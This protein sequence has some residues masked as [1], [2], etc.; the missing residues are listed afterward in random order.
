[1]QPT[2]QTG[3]AE[4]P[5]PGQG[6]GSDE[7][8]MDISLGRGNASVRYTVTGDNTDFKERVRKTMNESY[9]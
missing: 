8:N 4:D 2:D 1:M 5:L 9:T 6:D 7:E 3:R